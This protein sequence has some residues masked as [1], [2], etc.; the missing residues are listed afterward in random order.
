MVQYKRILFKLSGEALMG[1]T[2]NSV[3]PKTV[4]FMIKQIKTIVSLGTQVAIVIGGGNFFRGIA[5]SEALGIKRANADYMGMLATVMNG[6]LLKDA[7]TSSGLATKLFSALTI[8]NVVEGY[9][10]DKAID[11][12]NDGNVVVLVAGTGSPFFTTDSGA[13]LRGVELDADLLLKA[14]KVDGI[15]NKDPKKHDD[16]V[17]YETV[18]FDEAIALRLGVMDMAA[19][20][21]CRENNLSIK[22]CSIFEDGI[23]QRIVQGS[24]DGTLVV[25]KI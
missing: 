12:L 19:F 18:S 20:T 5:G 7:L 14:T 22:V 2:S 25:N 21:I 4:E 8:G 13:A 6:I 9:S 11:A 3:D 23:L 17:K 10:R 16:A 15:Y 1:D 24:S